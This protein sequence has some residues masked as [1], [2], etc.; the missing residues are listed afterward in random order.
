MKLGIGETIEFSDCYKAR[1]EWQHSNACRVFWMRLVCRANDAF[2]LD[3][4][5][6]DPVVSGPNHNKWKVYYM[7]SRNLSLSEIEC[8][9]A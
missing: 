3:G 7:K 8:I 6:L 1:Q 2:E 5:Q 9:I 4:V